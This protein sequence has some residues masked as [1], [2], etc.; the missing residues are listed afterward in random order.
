[1]YVCYLRRKMG[2]AGQSRL[3][4]TVRPVGYVLLMGG[5]C[6]A[7]ARLG[8]EPEDTAIRVGRAVTNPERDSMGS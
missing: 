2:A 3:L 6:R 8:L 4:R 5:P 1:V 7:R